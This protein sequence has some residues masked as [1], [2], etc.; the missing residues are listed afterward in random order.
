MTATPPIFVFGS[1]E[2]GR[3]GRG[4]AL[5]ARQH[6]GAIYGQ[7]EGR[8][9]NSYGIPT[10]DA[11]LQS[12]PLAAIEAGVARFLDYARRHPG[13]RFEVTPIGC[14]L[15]GYTPAQIAPFFRGAPANCELARELQQ[16]A[17][18]VADAMSGAHEPEGMT[19]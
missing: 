6:C 16:A 9:G 2:A 4:A 3:H 17:T 7:G 11:Q 12:L 8:Q 19:P 13:E 15:A 5:W 1:N 18:F 10:K 14:G